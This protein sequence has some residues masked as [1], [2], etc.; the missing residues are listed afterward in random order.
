MAAQG[1][2]LSQPFPFTKATDSYSDEE[3]NQWG[4]CEE[5]PGILEICSRGCAIGFYIVVNGPTYGTMWEG[6]EDF[7]SM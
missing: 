6:R 2:D 1:R 7:L 3:L 4:D 5:Y